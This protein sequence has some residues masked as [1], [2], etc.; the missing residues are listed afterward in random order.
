MANSIADLIYNQ[1]ATAGKPRTTTQQTT[2]TTT[3][4]STLSA[5]SPLD[6]GS[7]GLLLY[8]MLS[9]RNKTKLQETPTPPGVDMTSLI[10]QAPGTM[11]QQQNPLE[12]LMSLFGGMGGIGGAGGLR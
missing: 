11:S 5:K 12:L 2:G 10:G 8:L 7:L 1:M 6:L 3:G 4:T 9:G